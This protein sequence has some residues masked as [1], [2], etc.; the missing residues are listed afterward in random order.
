MGANN[1]SRGKL[2]SFS[3]KQK[4]DFELNA[5]FDRTPFP[6]YINNL[7]QWDSD[8]HPLAKQVFLVFAFTFPTSRS[9][10]STSCLI[11]IFTAA[12]SLL[13]Q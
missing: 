2:S 6:K 7:V 8:I 5:I 3:D 11:N 9:L 4:V 12:L 1:L 10:G 13:A